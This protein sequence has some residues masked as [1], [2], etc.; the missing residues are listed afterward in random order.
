MNFR[1]ATKSD[2][3]AMPEEKEEGKDSFKM[4]DVSSDLG[5][6][7]TRPSKALIITHLQSLL[8]KGSITIQDERILD[9]M[10]LYKWTDEANQQGAGA[11]PNKHD[12]MVMAT[13]LAYLPIEN[14]VS[15]R[16]R[17]LLDRINKDERKRKKPLFNYL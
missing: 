5:F 4:Q 7:T 1:A 9:E 15:E 16:K 10:R 8:R 12:D 6:R 13:M 17:G 2:L 11:P 3:L 14:V